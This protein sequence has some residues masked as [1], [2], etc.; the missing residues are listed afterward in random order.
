MIRVTYDLS[1]DIGLGNMPVTLFLSDDLVLSTGD[2]ELVTWNSS[3]GTNSNIVSVNSSLETG[4]KN[5]LLVVN[6]EFIRRESNYTNNVGSA[7]TTLTIFEK[8][9]R[10]LEVDSWTLDNSDVIVGETINSTLIISDSIPVTNQF[11]ILYLLSE[12]SVYDT[13]DYEL[14]LDNAVFSSIPQNEPLTIPP[15]TD[16]GTWYLLAYLDIEGL[17]YEADED[18]NHGAMAIHKKRQ[19]LS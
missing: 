6:K 5:I 11:S 16:P 1:S 17:W 7:S 18:N 19:R 3:V 10:D 9:R 2:F 13:D 14:L 8:A 4:E 15:A 12:D